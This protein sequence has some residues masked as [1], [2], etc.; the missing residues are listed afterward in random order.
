MQL[1]MIAL[2]ATL[3]LTGPQPE[4]PAQ[5]PG[6][7]ESCLVTLEDEREIPA[8]E[9]GVL[10]ELNVIEGQQVTKGEVLGRVDDRMAKK[11]E[12]VSQYKLTAARAEAEN[13]V[14]V[15]YAKAT[16]DVADAEVLQDHETNRIH[17]NTVPL[18]DMR[19]H[20]LEA[21]KAALGID[22]AEHEQKLATLKADIQQSEL[23][24]ASLDIERRQI[25]SPINGEVVKRHVR[26]GEWLKPGDPVVHV[27]RRDLLRV[28]ATL[29]G[30]RITPSEVEG[31]PVTVEVA[32]GHGRVERF[33]GKVVWVSPGRTNG[34]DFD[35][36]AEVYNRQENGKWL[37]GYDMDA[38]MTI[39]WQQKR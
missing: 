24:A 15:R 9:A 12:E 13:D 11:Q 14:N 7:V 39:H 38:R 19:R 32:L 22:Q 4:T 1:P 23:Q 18:F 29:D 35:V 33:P 3:A 6:V 17:P 10:W 30:N 20:Q 34:S 26:E 21:K 5:D 37:L 8:Q 2:A 31:K 28:R 16:R 27:V 36:W 25:I